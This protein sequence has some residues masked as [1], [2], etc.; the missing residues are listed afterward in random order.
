MAAFKKAA[1]PG[2]AVKECKCMGK[3]GKS[4]V[5]EVNVEREG[6]TRHTRVHAS[7]AAFVLS[8]SFPLN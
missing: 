7:E 2:V 3:C 5:A 4:P 1:P 8:Q 6:R